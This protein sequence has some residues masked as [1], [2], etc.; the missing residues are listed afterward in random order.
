MVTPTEID[1]QPILATFFDEGRWLTDFVTPDALEVQAL[2]KNLTENVT[3]MA[4]HV[5]LPE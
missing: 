2:H 1:N 4:F 5:F 3:D